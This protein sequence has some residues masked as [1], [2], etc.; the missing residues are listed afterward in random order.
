MKDFSVTI[1]D[2]I[3][4]INRRSGTYTISDLHENI[5]LTDKLIIQAGSGW[6]DK[7]NDSDDDW[8]DWDDDDSDSEWDD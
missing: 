7:D 6:S 5:L 4:T 2:K 1:D 3:V 8:G